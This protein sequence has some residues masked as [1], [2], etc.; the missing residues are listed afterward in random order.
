MKKERLKGFLLGLLTMTLIFSASFSVY[1]A[2]GSQNISASFNNI[3]LYVDQKLVTPKDASGSTVEPFIYNGT[4][5]L[6]VRAVA[7]ALGKEVSWDAVT[8]SVYLGTQPAA[9]PEK[10]PSA[11][12]PEKTQPVT[13]FSITS[14]A[15]LNTPQTVSVESYLNNYNATVT[16][17]EIIRGEKAWEMIK[18]KNRFNSEA[19][20]GREYI[21]AKV[22][23]KINSADEGKSVSMSQVAF[24]AF[25][26]DNSEYS[27]SVSV[28]T[29]EPTIRGDMYAGAEKDG[30]LAFEVK[31][32]DS[33]PK[34]VF[35]AKYNGTGGI[36]FKL[37]N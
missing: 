18:E 4:T 12:E 21:L 22:K 30:Y 31:K 28:V 24:T 32:D 17:T 6:P 36:W 1:A 13:N 20:E 5:Y 33:A 37:S 11:P 7:D 27:D 2:T 34:F 25:S 8:K 26:A 16:V 3:K 19:R 9:E 29:P 10:A 35:G 15:P 14:P 23:V